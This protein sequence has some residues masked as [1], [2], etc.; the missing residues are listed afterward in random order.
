VV[1]AVWETTAK[2]IYFSCERVHAQNH[3]RDV[4]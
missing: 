4:G 3:A 2:F 1:R